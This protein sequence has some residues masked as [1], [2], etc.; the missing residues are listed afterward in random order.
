VPKKG[1]RETK[2]ARSLES[3]NLRR[4]GYSYR[5][6][7]K[8]LE[9]SEAT[10]FRDVQEALSALD[11]VRKES[12]ERL[13][14]L[15]VERFDD[16]LIRLQKKI[17]KGDSFAI[18]TAMK[19]AEQRAKLLGLNAPTQIAPVNPDGSPLA[20]ATTEDLKARALAILEKL[21]S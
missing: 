16:Y 9:V 5:E 8:K 17:D 4:I 11:P 10:A 1:Q 20:G 19:V 3:L 15:E 18:K 13:R 6:I 12:A 21:A 7:G 2:A 14:E